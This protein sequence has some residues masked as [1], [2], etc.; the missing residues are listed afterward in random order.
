VQQRRLV[1]GHAHHRLLELH[2]D[3]PALRAELDDVALDL[4]GHAGHQLGA[5]QDR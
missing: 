4:D 2:L 1:G 3:E 5:L